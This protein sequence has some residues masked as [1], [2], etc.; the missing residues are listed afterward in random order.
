MLAQ[1]I[2]GLLKRD[3]RA[4]RREI[5]AYAKEPDL[6]RLPPGIANSA[7]NLALHLA[8]NLQYFVGAVLGGTAYVRDRDAEFSRRDVPRAELLR[9]IDAALDAV[10][11]G[12]DKVADHDLAQP[13]P[14]AVGGV[15]VTTEAF[16]LHLATH[17]TYHLGQVDYH[18][19]LIT[20]QP[21]QIRAVA[22]TELPSA[23]LAPPS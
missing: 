17:L 10:A 19:R 14:Q 7:G 1:S 23:T 21:A 2:G 3:L 18:R 9:E 15:R 13:F 20:G 12:M 16:L 11:R 6:W 22:V 5:E 8:G 4:L